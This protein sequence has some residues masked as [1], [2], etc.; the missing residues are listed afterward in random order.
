[1]TRRLNRACASAL[2]S[3]ATCLV[4]AGSGLPAATI[5]ILEDFDDGLLVADLQDAGSA[6]D[7]TTG[8]AEYAGSNKTRE[9]IRTIDSD[10]DS[11]NFRFE[12]TFT[13]S[14]AG[15]AW[16]NGFFGIGS[17]TPGTYFDSPRPAYY[18][19]LEARNSGSALRRQR[20]GASSPSTLLTWN[21][22]GPLGAGTHRIQMSKD[23][24]DVTWAIDKNYT[25]TFNPDDTLSRSFASDTNTMSTTD[26]RLFFGTGR[27]GPAS[28]FD[29]VAIV[30]EPSMIALAL[31]SLSLL[32]L[33]RRTR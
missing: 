18:L 22:L 23:G 17:G 5:P 31:G 2:R 26:W 25:G 21:D 6:F 11:A 8:T 33:R 30:P 12:A 13:F 24:D 20:D 29:D 1:M 16:A 28:S 32:M 9:Y 15:D 7:F 14:D 19:Q 4:L 27:N 3:I 10:Y